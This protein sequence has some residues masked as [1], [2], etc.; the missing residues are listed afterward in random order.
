MVLIAWKKFCRFED[1][2]KP[3]L[4]ALDLLREHPG[5][6]L[7]IDA[8]NGFE[9]DKADVEWAFGVLLP[10]MARTGCR[11][12]WF[13]MQ[14]VSGIEEEMDLW[15][16]EFGKYFEVRRTTALRET[17]PTLRRHP[18]TEGNWGLGENVHNN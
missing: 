7:A 18:S 6:D 11:T 13:I 3:T 14:E 17:T 12:V 16:K 15:G 8:R 2:R 4:F 1:Y 9:D 5:S 10:A